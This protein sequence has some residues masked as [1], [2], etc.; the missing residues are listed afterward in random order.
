MNFQ[1]DRTG[2]ILFVSTLQ[3]AL[4]AITW[5]DVIDAV[6]SYT[7]FVFIAFNLCHLSTNYSVHVLYISM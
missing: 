4:I 5:R 7:Y 2:K 3:S 1:T 6:I